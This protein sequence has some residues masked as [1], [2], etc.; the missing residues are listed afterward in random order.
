MVT[1]KDGEPNA[2]NLDRV[3]IDQVKVIEDEIV[4]LQDQ[5]DKGSGLTKQEASRLR[6][7]ET[8]YVAKNQTSQMSEDQQLDYY[9]LSTK[10]NKFGLSVQEMT[11]LRNLYRRLSELTDV[12]P[13]DYYFEAFNTAVNGVDVE[14]I[15]FDNADEWINSENVVLA[16]AESERFAEWFDRNHYQKTVYNPETSSYEK[17]YFRTKVW[18]VSRPSNPKYYK[19]TE[20]VK[21]T[22]NALQSK[23]NYNTIPSNTTTENNDSVINKFNILMDYF[24]N[25]INGTNGIVTGV[26]EFDA[27]ENFGLLNNLFVDFDI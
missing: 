9:N 2:L 6:W 4:S 19:K 10:A 24:K 1:D 23:Y 3:Q 25:S 18:S 7:Y 5:F 22:F 20:L 21:E 26:S 16:K 12:M 27:S 17:R 14:E 15:N 13:T 11:N 8:I